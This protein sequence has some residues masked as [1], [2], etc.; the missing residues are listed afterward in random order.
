MNR[1]VLGST[2]IRRKRATGVRGVSSTCGLLTVTMHVN[3][4]DLNSQRSGAGGCETVFLNVVVSGAAAIG[5]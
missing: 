2:T 4:F 1:G 3:R 5:G